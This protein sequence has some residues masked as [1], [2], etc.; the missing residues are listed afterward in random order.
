MHLSSTKFKKIHDRVSI[1]KRISFISS[2]ISRVHYQHLLLPHS[3]IFVFVIL[4]ML[5]LYLYILPKQKSYRDFL[6]LPNNW[7][8]CRLKISSILIDV[9]SASSC[10]DSSPRLPSKNKS[11]ALYCKGAQTER[12]AHK[13]VYECPG[14]KWTLVSW[15][16]LAVTHLP[17]KWLFFKN[18]F[19]L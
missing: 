2:F 15:W 8:N 19:H 16:A 12:S 10:L 18:Y 6:S 9:K 11:F 3:F 14:Y 17:G 7:R 4:F 13:F 5:G 1:R